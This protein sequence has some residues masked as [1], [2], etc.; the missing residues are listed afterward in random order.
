MIW[1]NLRVTSAGQCKKERSF[2]AMAINE[3]NEIRK[4]ARVYHSFNVTGVTFFL[5][6]C[7]VRVA[8]IDSVLAVIKRIFSK[9]AIELPAFFIF[10]S[11]GSISHSG[12]E[13][14]TWLSKSSWHGQGSSE[15]GILGYKC[16][17][18]CCYW[19]ESLREKK[20]RHLLSLSYYLLNAIWMHGI[21]KVIHTYSH[22]RVLQTCHHFT[23]DAA[24]LADFFRDFD[25]SQAAIMAL[26]Q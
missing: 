9:K 12:M 6:G 17:R 1:T 26:I 3:N 18:E 21:G 5:R 8:V 15:S 14:L 24:N 4:I 10:F 20:C 7:N 16:S 23:C 13:F 25:G 19:R 2:S 22:S 11:T